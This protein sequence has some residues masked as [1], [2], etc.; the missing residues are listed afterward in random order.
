MA[1]FVSKSNFFDFET[2]QA[3]IGLV[4]S[5]I[6]CSADTLQTFAKTRQQNTDC[7]RVSRK[8]NQIQ[9]NQAI[10]Q[11]GCLRILSRNYYLAEE[12]QEVIQIPFYF[13][14]T[15]QCCT[16]CFDVAASKAVYAL[17][18]NKTHIYAIAYGSLVS[19]IYYI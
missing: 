7:Q 1:V 19:F 11:P 4:D 5:I 10:F 6:Y 18:N 17:N 9:N 16:T 15:C 13:A 12:Y 8:R 3:T 14:I 2:R